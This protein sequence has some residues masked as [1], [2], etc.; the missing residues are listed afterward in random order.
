MAEPQSKRAHARRRYPAR[1]NGVSVVAS[2]ASALDALAGLR[3]TFAFQPIIDA[4]D[5]QVYSY[6]ALVR[7][8]GGESA[9]TVFQ[10]VGP[11][12]VYDFDRRAR[13]LAIAQ[14]A[15]LR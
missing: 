14:A 7:G 2:S 6:E 13:V 15:R 8:P 5:R 12:D 9:A 10:Q 4:V 1:L 3:F 11:A